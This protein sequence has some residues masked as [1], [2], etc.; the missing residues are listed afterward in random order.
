M[1]KHDR[2]L[3]RTKFYRQLAAEILQRANGE[4][5]HLAVY[6]NQPGGCY[7]HGLGGLRDLPGTKDL[8]VYAGAAGADARRALGIAATDCGWNKVTDQGRLH[9][10]KC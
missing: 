8:G 2:V 5:C 3:S 10:R 9:S 4:L 7:H 1:K 6:S